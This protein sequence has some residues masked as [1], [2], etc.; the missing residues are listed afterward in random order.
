METTETFP[1]TRQDV[2]NLKDT[3]VGA[4]KDLRETAA[5]HIDKAKG[6]V[7]E[8]KTTAV[9]AAKDL[10]STATVH[11][12]KAKG[13]LRELASHAQTEGVQQLNQVRGQLDDV[14]DSARAYISARPLAA[15]GVAVAVGFLIGLSRRRR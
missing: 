7:A 5:T 8:L 9:E 14:A 15:V 1:N 3:A 4:A 11:A 13:Q 10:K 2:A 12:E 6:H